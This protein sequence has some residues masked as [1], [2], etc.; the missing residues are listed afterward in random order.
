MET[1]NISTPVPIN[2]NI[3]PDEIKAQLGY[4]GKNKYMHFLLNFS[5]RTVGINEFNP[6]YD[7]KVSLPCLLAS[8]L[9]QS[10]YR[11]KYFI[12]GNTSLALF[13]LTVNYCLYYY[14][15]INGIRF[16]DYYSKYDFSKELL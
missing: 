11:R 10:H 14:L 12:V 13:S 4:K 5:P 7:P 15:I 2:L 1:N 3:T 16:Y 9:L 6:I 8:L